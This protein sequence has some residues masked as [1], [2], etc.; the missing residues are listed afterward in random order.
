MK[1]KIRHSKKIVLSLLFIGIMG[2]IIFNATF[3]LHAHRTACGQIILHSHPFSKTSET[4]NPNTQHQH[5]KIELQVIQSL[6][7]FV[8]AD[9]EVNTLS[10]DYFLI[11]KYKIQPCFIQPFHL[12]TLKNYRAPPCIID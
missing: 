8:S 10:P 6:D 4:E 12:N 1:S 7:Y 3:F 5:T 9:W 2:G 11:A